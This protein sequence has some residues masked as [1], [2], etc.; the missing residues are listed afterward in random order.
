[1]SIY[2]FLLKQ[3][4]DVFRALTIY[5]QELEKVGLCI[6]ITKTGEI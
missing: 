6:E 5:P 4:E 3:V 2:G 1:M